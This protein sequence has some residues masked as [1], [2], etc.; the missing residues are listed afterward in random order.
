MLVSLPA[1]VTAKKAPG[2]RSGRLATSILEG[3]EAR[4]GY[5]VFASVE[6]DA[7]NAHFALRVK[8]DPRSNRMDIR[9]INEEGKEGEASLADI[10]LSP[11][12]DWDVLRSFSIRSSNQLQ[13]PANEDSILELLKQKQLE[14][15]MLERSEVKQ[16]QELINR[17]VDERLEWRKNAPRR[18]Q[19]NKIWQKYEESVSQKDVGRTWRRL[20]ADM[21]VTC[22]VCN[23]GEGMSHYL[24]K[25]FSR[26]SIYVR[27]TLSL[28][29][30][31]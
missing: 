9:L 4:E 1:A 16:A 22:V 17:V 14:L 2:R 5:P 19:Q 25:Y 24:P 30:L 15:E 10:N 26:R 6:G 29:V 27:L 8:K 7:R 13:T 28:V 3:Q 11:S 12:L 23:T 20:E 21:D 18:H 31:F